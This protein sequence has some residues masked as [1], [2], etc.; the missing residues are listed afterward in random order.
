MSIELIK[1]TISDSSFILRAAL[2]LSDDRIINET[3]FE[4]YLNNVIINECCDVWLITSEKEKAGYALLN[5]MPMLRFRGYCVEIEEIVIVKEH[6]NKG[7]GKEF[8]KRLIKHYHKDS[9]VRKISIKTDDTEGSAR[10]YERIFDK[11]GMMYYQQYL[12]KV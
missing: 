5:R 8:L 2:D 4:P 11:T 12:N 1:A 10:L 3:N 6:R 9:L 7:L